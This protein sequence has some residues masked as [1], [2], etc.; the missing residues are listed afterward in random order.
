VTVVK[1][2]PD[3]SD[4]GLRELARS[5][6]LLL[7]IGIGWLVFAWVVLSFEFKTVWAVAIFAGTSFI[8]G[9]IS[10]IVLASQLTSWRWLYYLLGFISF[11]A[12]VACF[13]WPGQTFL[14]LAAILAWYLLFKG[15]FDIFQ[16]F[17]LRRVD[18]LWWL[19]LLVGVAEILI[20][21]WAIGY[22]GRSIALLVVWVGAMALSRGIVSIILA[23]KVRGLGKGDG[24]RPA[25][26]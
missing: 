7:L 17:A 16:A 21:F 1:I 2:V 8:V 5:W 11:A 18:D 26:A 3:E 23:F 20:G 15:I 24:P 10:E 6:W 14:V 4:D 13:V 9:G 12:G 25:V 19:T 22:S